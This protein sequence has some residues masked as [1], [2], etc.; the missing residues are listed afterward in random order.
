MIIY[1]LSSSFLF[2]LL[3]L[4]Y[5]QNGCNLL[6]VEQLLRP[7]IPVPL[8]LEKQLPSPQHLE[9]KL[10]SPQVLQQILRHP[11]QILLLREVL[12]LLL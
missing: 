10:E 3:Q 7:L 5:L 6:A 1:S 8:L 4:E 2:L 12:Q 9:L 11:Q